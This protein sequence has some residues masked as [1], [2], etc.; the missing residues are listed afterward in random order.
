MAIFLKKITFFIKECI[1]LYHCKKIVN[2]FICI[3]KT[4]INLL[5]PDRPNENTI[6]PKMNMSCDKRFMNFEF[7]QT[8]HVQRF[9]QHSNPHSTRSSIFS[10]HPHTT[11]SLTHLG[12][13]FSPLTP[14]FSRKVHHLSLR[15][16]AASCTKFRHLQQQQCCQP[17][18]TLNDEQSRKFYL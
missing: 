11:Q 14:I 12:H 1:K 17:A 6:E 4:H 5:S 15:R 8:T 2:Y 9:N 16:A 3:F 13:C 7:L 10:N 18:L